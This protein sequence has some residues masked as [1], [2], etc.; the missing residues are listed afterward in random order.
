VVANELPRTGALGV[1]AAGHRILH[2]SH[3]RVEF[4]A[5]KLGAIWESTA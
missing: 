2:V 3:F 5:E 1:G 4:L